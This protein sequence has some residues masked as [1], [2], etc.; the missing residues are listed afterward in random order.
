MPITSTMIEAG[1]GQRLVSNIALIQPVH[2]KDEYKAFGFTVDRYEA[3]LK[4]KTY[5]LL[6]L[7]P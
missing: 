1:K 5:I 3:A 6:Q 4:Q 2:F 7:C